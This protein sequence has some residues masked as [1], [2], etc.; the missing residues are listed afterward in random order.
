MSESARAI[1]AQAI[2]GDRDT[3]LLVGSIEPSWIEDQ[4]CYAIISTIIDLSISGKP[5]TP[6]TIASR[7]AGVIDRKECASLF[8]SQAAVKEYVESCEN[9]DGSRIESHIEQIKLDY[10]RS[11]IIAGAK[12]VVDSLPKYQTA[13]EAASSSIEIMAS[14]MTSTIGD[15]G[16]VDSMKAIDSWLKSREEAS[17]IRSWDFPFQT[18]QKRAKFKQSEILVFAAPSESGKS[19]FGDQMLERGCK[20]GSRVALFTGEMTPE[21]HI[22]RLVKMGGYSSDELDSDRAK[23]RLADIASWDFTIYDG[24]ITIDRIRAACV[25]ARAIGR[26]YHMVIVDHVHLMAFEGKNGYRIAL[27]DAM[28]I[29][30]GEIANKEK[31]GVVLLCQLRKPE[32]SDPS[33]RPRKSDIRESAAIENI[34]DWIFLMA[35]NNDDDVDSTE[36]TIWCD[37]RRGGRRFPTIGVEIHPKLNR[38]VEIPAGFAPT[39]IV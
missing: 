30:K 17:F 16:A 14:G 34:A 31:C 20:S 4:H 11:S 29:F 8:S 23:R 10:T 19:W 13:E 1:I 28:S 6:K 5:I 26:P 27:N 32:N 24:L 3:S 39:M 9:P 36:S 35:R 21:E 12:R 2:K 33:R 15:G 38:L 37:K 7:I 22:E 25:R 18:W